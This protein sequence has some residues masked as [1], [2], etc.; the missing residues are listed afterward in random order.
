MGRRLYGSHG[1]FVYLSPHSYQLLQCAFSQLS[2]MGAVSFCSQSDACNIP[3]GIICLAWLGSLTLFTLFS[4]AAFDTFIHHAWSDPNHG[5]QCPV[6]H[7]AALNDHAE[8][9]LAG[10]QEPDVWIWST[11]RSFDIRIVIPILFCLF[12]PQFQAC[13]SVTKSWMFPCVFRRFCFRCVQVSRTL[14]I[15]MRYMTQQ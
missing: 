1:T 10:L 3:A 5:H 11:Y 8:N 9:P 4:E 15:S 2:T 6:E 13:Y 7:S 14:F 12:P